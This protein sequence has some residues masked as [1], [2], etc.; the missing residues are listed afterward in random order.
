AVNKCY[1]PAKLEMSSAALPESIVELLGAKN[2]CAIP[3]KE[4][5]REQ[6]RCKKCSHYSGQNVTLQVRCG[7]ATR[8]IR[9]DI[10]ERDMFDP[11]TK[12]PEHTS[13]TMR[14]L[15]KLDQALGPGVMEKPMFL[16]PDPPNRPQNNSPIA[17]NGMMQ[18]IAQG[19]YD[20]L[21]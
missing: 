12:T 4:L 14:L 18:D 19:S 2:V 3:A 9:S 8:L 7:G 5:R 16:T 10:F 15:V 20:S 13:R 11:T 1:A 21:F 6:K 17:E